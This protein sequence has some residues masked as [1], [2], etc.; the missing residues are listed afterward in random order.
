MAKDLQDTLRVLAGTSPRIV[1]DA[2]Y[3]VASEVLAVSRD[4]TPVDLGN[5]KRSARAHPA[6]ITSAFISTRL[7]YGDEAVDYALAVH[8]RI[9]YTAA[10]GTRKKVHHPVG[11][12]KYLESAM[13]D[14]RPTWLR[15]IGAKVDL[16]K[17]L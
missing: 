1:A 11:R 3:E 2:L 8:E 10:D 4:R 6:Q 15:R 14:A 17:G 16:R 7:T 9:F 5:L 13:D 12:A